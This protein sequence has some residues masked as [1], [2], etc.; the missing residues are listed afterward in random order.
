M[1][2]RQLTYTVH[3]RD[4]LTERK[5]PEEWVERAVFEPDRTEEGAEG[6]VHY[7]RAYRNMMA[8]SCG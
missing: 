3:A 5:I 1:K 6:T 4:M 2:D 7:L 8:E